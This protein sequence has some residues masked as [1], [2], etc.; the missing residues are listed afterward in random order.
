MRDALEGRLWADHHHELSAAVDTLL[1]D[2]GHVFRRLTARLYDAPWQR[3]S[4]K[5]HH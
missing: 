5:S 1:K 2:T 4:R 3:V